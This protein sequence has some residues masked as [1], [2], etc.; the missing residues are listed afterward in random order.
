[1][2]SCSASCSEVSG[3][4]SRREMRSS[5]SA[6]SV[7][8]AAGRISSRTRSSCSRASL[9]WRSACSAR[10]RLAC[11]SRRASSSAAGRSAAVFSRSS[12]RSSAE[13]RRATTAAAS[14][15]SA[16]ESPEIPGSG[17]SISSVSRSAAARRASRAASSSS[18]HG[19]DSSGRKATS[20]PAVR[21][22]SHG[23]GS[24]SSAWRSARTTTGCCWR[25]RMSMRLRGSSKER[26][27][28][29]SEKSKPSSSLTGMKTISSGN[30]RLSGEKIALTFCCARVRGASPLSRK[31]R[32][33]SA[34]AGRVVDERVEQ[35]LAQHLGGVEAEQQLGGLAPLGDRA[36]AVG[37][38]EEPVDQ[39]REEAVERVVGTRRLVDVRIR[40]WCLLDG[41]HGR[42]GESAT[43][44][45]A[46]LPH[47]SPR[48]SPPRIGVPASW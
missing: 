16:I 34:S 29:K 26:S 33:A 8:S 22:P 21:Q 40:G 38:D 2:R 4:C 24:V 37:Q 31:R 47:G 41:V 19:V 6:C 10:S 9:T 46:R 30:V 39:L 28:R 23:C 44:P 7:V 17:S 11:A 14:S 15:R 13:S 3:V 32:H 20:V 43:P 27:S 1:M 45:G 42:V 18:T 35:P 25:M 48:P 12:M 36:L 5:S